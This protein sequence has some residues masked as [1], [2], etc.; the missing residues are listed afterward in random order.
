MVILFRASELSI[1]VLNIT[2]ALR[3]QTNMMIL[4]THRLML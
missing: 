2:A 1:D 4:E 3:R